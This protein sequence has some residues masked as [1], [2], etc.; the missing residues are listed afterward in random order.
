M[1]APGLI[2]VCANDDYS[3][4]CQF[5]DGKIT[6]FCLQDLIN[7]GVFTRLKDKNVFKEALT[8]LNDTAAWDLEGNRDET[9]CID[10]DRWVLYTSEEV[11]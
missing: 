6:R 1:I 4:T 8:I 7:K 11:N 10:I 9:K 3:I 5:A 2:Q